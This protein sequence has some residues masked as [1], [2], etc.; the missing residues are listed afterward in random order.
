MSIKARN[1]QANRPSDI[2]GDRRRVSFGG[3][4]RQARRPVLPEPTNGPDELPGT[5]GTDDLSGL[6]GDDTFVG[7]DG[8]DTISGGDGLDRVVYS[9]PREDYHQDLLPDGSILVTKPDGSTDTLTGI[10][11]IEFDDG[12][13]IF[14]IDGPAASFGYLLYQ[15]AYD[16]VPDEA[17]LR[18]WNDI[19]E[20]LADSLGPQGAILAVAA[21]FLDADEFE[22]NYGA[23]PTDDDFVDAL[24]ENALGRAPDDAGADFWHHALADDLSREAALLAFTASVENVANNAPNI[25]DGFW[26]G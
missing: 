18:F 17:G 6:G 9:G 15:A 5:S 11:R 24:Y 22:E 1:R 2:R 14:D 23:N 25:D 10:E 19:L 3:C 8:P 21:Y 16:R 26:V 7:S 13:F 20:Q 12:A 4:R